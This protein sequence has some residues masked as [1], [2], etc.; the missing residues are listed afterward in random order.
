MTLFHSWLAFVEQSL[1]NDEFY[2]PI[3][4]V[5]G[6]ALGLVYFAALRW[7]HGYMRR[8]P[9]LFKHWSAP[10]AEAQIYRMTKHTKLSFL[11][12]ILGTLWFVQLLVQEAWAN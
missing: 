12:L 8:H 5:V 7:L 9:E 3:A 4:F 10:L 6:G 2:T 1:K 11:F